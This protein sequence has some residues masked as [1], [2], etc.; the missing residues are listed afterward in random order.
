M[1]SSCAFIEHMLS[2]L[3]CTDLFRSVAS[4]D[5]GVGYI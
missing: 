4:A 3:L 1:V 5:V 2:C